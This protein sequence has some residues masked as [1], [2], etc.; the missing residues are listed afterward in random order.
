[1]TG[2]QPAPRRAR[3]AAIFIFI[4]LTLDVLARGG[5]IPVVPRL[6]EGFVGGSHAEA[7]RIGGLLGLVWA[8]MQLLFTPVQGALSDHFGRRPVLLL[9]MTGLGLDYLLMG[10]APSLGWLFVARA[11]SGLTAASFSTANAYIA[12]VTPPERRAGAYG[13]LG[14]AFGIGFVLGPALGGYAGKLD[15]RLPFWVSAALS[16]LNAIYGYLILPESLPPERRSRFSL[17]R[18]NPVG[19]LR[20]L[21]SD[22]RLA[23]LG[24]AQFFYYIGHGVYPAV[25][26]WFTMYRYGWNTGRTGLALAVAGVASIVVQGGLVGPVVGRRGGPPPQPT[27]RWLRFLCGL[28]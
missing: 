17:A 5:V 13:F 20:L 4:T 8:L 25:F 23:G 18:A 3:A 21:A 22:A 28:I 14:A 2:L 19:A 11:I 26:V 16:L 10:F 1:M 9:S 7:V 27:A 24:L 15:P 6:V 12:D